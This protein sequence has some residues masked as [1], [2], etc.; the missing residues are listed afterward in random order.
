MEAVYRGR[1]PGLKRPQ[2]QYLGVNDG[3]AQLLI[4]ATFPV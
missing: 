4:C 3:V 2:A 1:E